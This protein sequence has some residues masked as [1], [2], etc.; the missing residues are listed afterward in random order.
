[1]KN[2]VIIGATSGIGREIAIKYA[3]QGWTV[4][5]TGRRI[6][7][8]EELKIMYPNLL[9]Y[10]TMDIRDVKCTDVL[11]KLVNEMGGMDTLFVNAGVGS[12]NPELLSEIELQ[13]VET[14][15]LGFT[16]VIDWGFRYFRD[17][18]SGHI[19]VTSSVASI[20]AMYQAPAYSA[21][22]RYIRH[23]VDCLAQKAN[24]DK[25]NI[26][27]TTLLPG[28][29]E[30]A[31]LKADKYPLTIPLPR[32]ARLIFRAIEKKKRYAFIPWWW[33][34]IA[35]AWRLVPRAVMEKVM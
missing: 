22:K 23:Y 14:N 8:L 29:I 6:A 7:L 21:T 11:Q 9:H 27:F 31:L 1:M 35:F 13:T 10:A 20:G 18:K 26:R 24:H 28:F 25:L 12:Q 32:A 3:E 16:N 4:G 30:T 2:I 19:A 34:L 17:R 15:A 33:G 5:V